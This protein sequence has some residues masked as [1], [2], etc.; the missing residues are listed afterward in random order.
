MPFDPYHHW[1]GISPHERPADHYRLLGLKVGESSPAVIE[2]A[3]ARQT[4]YVRRFQAGEH[5][6]AAARILNEIAEAAE[7][8]LDPA[9]RAVYLDRLRPP[10]RPGPRQGHAAESRRPTTP[11]APQ[12]QRP[13]TPRPT[14]RR[15]TP[16]RVPPRDVDH[17]PVSPRELLRQREA[18]RRRPQPQP[19]RWPVVPAAAVLLAGIAVAALFALRPWAPQAALP[20]AVASAPIAAAD[21]A[22]AD[23]A[24]TAETAEAGDE[25]VQ[26]LAGLVGDD[27]AARRKGYATLRLKDV[28]DRRRAEVT[29]VLLPLLTPEEPDLDRMLP[30]ALRWA[31]ERVARRLVDLADDRRTP[32]RE[33]FVRALA[34]LGDPQALEALVDMGLRA[35]PLRPE[36]VTALRRFGAAGAAAVRRRFEQYQLGAARGSPLQRSAVLLLGDVGGAESLLFLD[37]Q[38]GRSELRDAIDV[39]AAA[40][41]QRVGIHGAVEEDDGRDALV[42][43]MIADVRSGDDRAVAN[44]LAVLADMAVVPDRRDAVVDTLL[45]LVRPDSLWR[46]TALSAAARWG[47]RRMAERLL[48]TARRHP[49]D[50]PE[51]YVRALGALGDPRAVPVLVD[52][53]LA[54]PDLWQATAAAVGTLGAAGEKA[55]H[56]VFDERD[57]SVAES[58]R[59]LGI[60]AAV[61]TAASDAFLRRQAARTRHRKAAKA[62]IERI[63]LRA[64][65]QATVHSAQP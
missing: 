26:A 21:D 24:E 42:D 52:R 47:D 61:G 13:P 29:D 34:D 36:A 8:L 11:E 20:T 64:G 39:A 59:L 41:R 7:V 33:R 37:R 63:R 49:G 54:Q 55:L 6:E 60:L 2:A 30:L 53:A 9:E 43:R 15:P 51:P 46:N 14:P 23:P 12:R 57:W 10:G 32:R 44:G 4:G 48:D 17:R 35:T 28:Q 65:A 62:A 58:E 25:I 50:L 16:R 27:T 5:D 1:L 45:P 22:P 31:D 38:R 3:L 19:Q 18:R 40:I 56:R